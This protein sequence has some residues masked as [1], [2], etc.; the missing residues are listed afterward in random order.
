MDRELSM[1]FVRVTEA[2]AVACG[3]LIGV[4]AFSWSLAFFEY[5]FQI[6]ANR[7]GF[8]KMAY[9]TKHLNTIINQK[10]L[11]ILKLKKK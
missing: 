4:V 2:A 1:E 6:P 5:L 3:R 11:M 10:N 8:I 9:F 7:I